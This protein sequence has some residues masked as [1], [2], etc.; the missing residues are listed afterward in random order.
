MKDEYYSF[1]ITP[2]TQYNKLYRIAA[3][4]IS[5]LPYQKIKYTFNER[6]TDWFLSLLAV[7]AVYLASI[8]SVSTILFHAE[9]SIKPARE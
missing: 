8:V 5:F 1:K 3:G 6:Q 2:N 9:A 4:K 7:H